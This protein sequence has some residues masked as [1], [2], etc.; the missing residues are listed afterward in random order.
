[1]DQDKAATVRLAKFTALQNEL[2]HY[3]QGT[4]RTVGE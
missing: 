4:D 2:Q 3:T 1:M